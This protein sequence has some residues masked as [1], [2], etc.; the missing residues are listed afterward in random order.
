MALG[1]PALIRACLFDL[2]GVITDTASVHAAAWKETFDAFLRKREG[3]G[4][5]PFSVDADYREFVDG[6]PRADG[7]RCFLASRGMELPDGSPDNPPGL[8]TVHG[9]GHWKTD[10]YEARIRSQGVG[11]YQDTMAYLVAAREQG[12]LT[13]VVTSSANCREVL[14][15]AHAETLFDAWIDGVV[16]AKRSLRGKPHPDTFLAAAR[17]L[18][19]HPSECAV[20][21]DAQAGMDAGRSGHF[22]W[23]VGVDRTGQADGLYAHGADTVVSDL[24]DLAGT[25]DRRNRT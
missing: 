14:R 15:A 22:G 23:V 7:V 1:L 11:V 18:G 17:D 16:A 8:D 10:L 13:A 4:F 3:D 6:R 5:R 20:F 24:S 9:L 12:L 21:E 19:Q 2:D 25:P